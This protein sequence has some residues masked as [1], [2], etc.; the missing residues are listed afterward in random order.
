[1]VHV[2]V[3]RHLGSGAGQDQAVGQMGH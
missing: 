1:V 2:A 3:Q